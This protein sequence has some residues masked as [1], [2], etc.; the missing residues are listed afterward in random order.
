MFPAMI[1]SQAIFNPCTLIGKYEEQEGYVM[2]EDRTIVMTE[3]Y[4]TSVINDRPDYSLYYMKD[5]IFFK[6]EMEDSVLALPIADYQTIL[7][8]GVSYELRSVATFGVEIRTFHYL[9]EVIHGYISLYE[10]DDP[11][12]GQRNYYLYNGAKM[13]LVSEENF[14]KEMSDYFKSNAALS[15]QIK[16]GEKGYAQIEAIVNEFNNSR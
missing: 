1:F 4:N 5:S 11:H 6:K 16:K 2:M 8:D 9:F 12:T 14:Q 10:F 13:D 15:K 3:H 7:V